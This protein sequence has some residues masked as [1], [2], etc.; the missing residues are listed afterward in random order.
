MADVWASTASLAARRSL[1]WRRYPAD[2][3]P[4]WVAEMDVEL[5][6]PVQDALVNAVRRSDTG[7]AHP[8]GLYEAFAGFAARRYGWYAD[9]GQMALMPDVAAAAM[10][11]LRVVTA[12]GDGVVVNTP[13]YPPFFSWI[14]RTGRRLVASPLS[15][16]PDGYA[17][18]LARLEADFAAGARAYLL[19]NPHNPTGLVH[20][21]SELAS[22]A[23]L[24]DR[25]GVRVIADEIHA[26]LTFMGHAHI[27]FAML[28][29]DA[30]RRAFIL[31]SASKA[32]NLAGL[33]CALLV[34]GEA[35]SDN[36]ARIP[37]EVQYGAG[38]LGVL[39]SIAAFEAGEVWLD[40]LLAALDT[41]RRLLADLCASHLPAVGYRLPQATYLAWLDF[42]LCGL[43][44]DPA[45]VLLERAKVA[46]GPGPEFGAEGAGFARLNLATAPELL[47]EAVF[48]IART[49]PDVAVLRRGTEGGREVT[50][51][52][53][54]ADEAPVSGR[55]RPSPG[56]R[57]SR[58]K[59]P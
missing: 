20:S 10:E 53:A 46:L 42:R 24:A 45:T 6:E 19:C 12:P 8:N 16:G 11:A 43:D 55:R 48:Q 32:W 23:R 9:P 5:A 29:S 35:A 47:T 17:L 58:R 22:V 51:P 15:H 26:P 52:R 49:M 50:T 54:D 37:A 41:N 40:E 28:D 39:A 34:A 25:Y 7:Y 57:V 44:G 13:V 30:A 2:V 56:T 59:R 4:L 18:D 1:K 33:K 3:L 31:V 38:L 14:E 21:W 36:L 27:P